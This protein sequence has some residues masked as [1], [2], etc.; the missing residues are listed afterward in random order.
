M[1]RRHCWWDTTPPCTC[2]P[3]TSWATGRRTGTRWSTPASRPVGSPCWRCTS[4]RGRTLPPGVAGSPACSPPRTARRPSERCAG[5]VRPA[6]SVPPKVSEGTQDGGV[7]LTAAA[8]QADGS[9]AAAPAL[10]LEQRGQGQAGARHADGVPEGDGPTVDVDDVRA[11]AEVV[12]GGQADD[13][14]ISSDIVNV[15]GGAIALGHPVG[16]SGTRLALTSLRELKR[17]GGGTA[18]QLEQR[19]QGQAGAR[20]ADG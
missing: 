18:L 15:N 17:R 9:R 6:A 13:L 4:G 10:Q 8:A 19:G 20:H 16:M 2:S 14:G 1:P 7:A 5:A 3:G 12:G 11:D